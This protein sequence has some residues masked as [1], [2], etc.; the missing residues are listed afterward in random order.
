[1]RLKAWRLV[2]RIRRSDRLYDK[3]IE[4]TLLDLL[5]AN[6]I[7][8]ATVWSGVDGFGKRGKAIRKVE[9]IT[10]DSPIMIEVVDEGERLEPLLTEIRQ[11]VGDNGLVTLQEVGII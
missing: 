1:L 8:G 7:W 5:R 2:V 9:G 10:F 3:S 6:K 11:I 4:K